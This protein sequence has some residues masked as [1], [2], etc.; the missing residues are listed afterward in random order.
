MGGRAR[1]L[2]AGL[3]GGCKLCASRGRGQDICATT[4]DFA[5][6]GGGP[7]ADIFVHGAQAGSDRI[8]DFVVGTGHLRLQDGVSLTSASYPSLFE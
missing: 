4:A 3:C 8:S 7:G 5:I 1:L 6:I 2:T